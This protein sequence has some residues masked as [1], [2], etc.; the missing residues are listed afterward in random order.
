[1]YF[2]REYYKSMPIIGKL[3]AVNIIFVNKIHCMYIKNK[4]IIFKKFLVAFVYKR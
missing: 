1:M 3:Y 4:K 2:A